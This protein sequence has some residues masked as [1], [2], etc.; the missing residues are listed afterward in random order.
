MDGLALPPGSCLAWGL[1]LQSAALGGDC[2]DLQEGLHQR[3][4]FQDCA[5]SVPIPVKPPMDPGAS[6]TAS[7]TGRCFGSVFC[8]VTAPFLWVQCMQGFDCAL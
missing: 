4:F 2:G 6:R 7:N 3:V 1:C 5:T 8:G